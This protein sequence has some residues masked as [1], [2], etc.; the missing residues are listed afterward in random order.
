M[1]TVTKTKL[2]T[3]KL[4]NNTPNLHLF[5][6]MELPTTFFGSSTKIIQTIRQFIFQL[7]FFFPSNDM[8]HEVRTYNVTSVLGISVSL[9][10]CF[11]DGKFFLTIC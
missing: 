3:K 9:T 2:S 4:Q 11:C 5:S 8:S 10:T 1:A 6:T 7:R